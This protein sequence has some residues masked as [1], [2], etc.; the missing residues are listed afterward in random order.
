[1]EKQVKKPSVNA[2]QDGGETEQDLMQ[3][4]GAFGIEGAE[5]D[6]PP[7]GIA[8]ALGMPFGNDSPDALSFPPEVPANT[9]VE[10]FSG[11]ESATA[12][13][14]VSDLQ[15]F[16]HGVPPLVLAP[17]FVFNIEGIETT[18]GT[19]FYK[20]SRTLHRP[21]SE[22]DNAVPLIK[23][24]HLGIRVY[25]NL[26]K[27]WWVAAGA[28]QGN[29]WFK[30][31]DIPGQ[32][33]RKASVLNGSTTG[34]R[35][36][37]IDRGNASHTLNF[38][39]SE[40]YARGRLLVYTR[41][42]VFYG[43]T[44]KYTPWLGRTLTFTTVPSLRIRA[45]G[46]HYHRNG[47]LRTA[48][49]L[50][51]FIA[52]GVFMRKTYPIS[53]FNFV[54]YDV[55]HFNGD[56]TNGSGGGCGPGW[57]ALMNVLRQ[58]YA[59]SGRDAIHYALMKRGIPTAYG[60]CGGGNVG[61]SF[62]GGG[63]TMAQE[64]GHALGRGH[65]PGAPGADASYPAYTHPKTPT[66]G[67]FGMDYATGAIYK[68][69]NS[70]DFMGYAG[71]PWV[72][73]YTYRGLINGVRT[74]PSPSPAASGADDSFADLG[75]D[76][77]FQREHLYLSFSVSCNGDVDLQSGFSL[78]GPSGNS[79][80]ESTDH[81]IELHDGQDNILWAKRLMLEG[82]H[83]NHDDSHTQYSESI[84]MLDGAAKLVFKCGHA[85]GAT[86]IDI[87]KKA[88]T[89]SIKPLKMDTCNEQ[90]G[91]VTLNW[92]S[93]CG[94]GEKVA[95]IIRFS[96]DGGKNWRPV[97]VELV[98]SQY[99]VDFDQLPGGKECKLQVIVSTT[100]RTAMAETETFAVAQTA[101]QAMISPVQQDEQTQK[102][103]VVELAG[104]AYSP[105]GCAEEGDCRW[106][107]SL[108]GDLG[109]GEYLIANNLTPGEH[110]ISLTAPD[111]MGGKTRAEHTVLVPPQN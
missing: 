80:G 98:E 67:E 57:G 85:A 24:K 59:A 68:P 101:A 27:P 23:R 6:Y 63:S 110:V 53:R 79:N 29:V 38:R 21:H 3:V 47:I 69:S 83:Q 1:M 90:S 37:S 40:F 95:S 16:G 92:E 26:I 60:G 18:Q 76:L 58:R 103:G 66:I 73:P 54:S 64:I 87:P 102:S 49:V 108:D 62:V 9:P 106:N 65:A 30:R 2:S 100:L 99:M 28:V 104:C 44:W 97:A 78:V 88:P 39:I 45:H 34:R 11:T 36:T 4:T 93:Q 84:P 7:P 48:P 81:S 50:S 5:L 35:A 19:Q 56:L 51:D 94:K 17:A 72:S 74:Q 91:T 86:T 42:K 15:A 13:D 71:N 82:A 46:V 20:S 96:N 105:D 25:P 89:V 52:T 77:R 14:E 70:N 41:C 61:A 109:C 32:S 33:Y 22:A 107:S 10:A 43:G 55:I 8:E 75:E 31:I 12:D 111:G